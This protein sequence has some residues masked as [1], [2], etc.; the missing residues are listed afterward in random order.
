[1]NVGENESNESEQ[2]DPIMLIMLLNLPIII[3]R[4]SQKFHL[5]AIL[6]F[7]KNSQESSYFFNFL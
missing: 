7:S 6:L 3:S 1:M 4:I 5:L 2:N